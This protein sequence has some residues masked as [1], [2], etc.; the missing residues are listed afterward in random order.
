MDF[1]QPRMFSR[2]EAL[3]AGFTDDDLRRG[4]A[5]G[6]LHTVRRGYFIRSEVYS[7]LGPHARH[8]ALAEAIHAESSN[9]TVFSHVSAAVLHRM[10]TWDVPLDKVTFTIGRTYAGK[11][12]RHRIL[13]GSPIPPADLTEVDG[14]PVTTPARTVVDL[15]RTLAL[16]PAV[17]VGDAALRTGATTRHDIDRAL[18]ESRNRTGIARA[19][20]AAAM[21]S[22]RSDSVG[23]T[24]SRMLLDTLPLPPPLLGQWVYDEIGIPIGR[25]SFLYPDHGVLG[26]FEG[27]G[28][29]GAHPAPWSAQ[30][31]RRRD[32]FRSLG[33][34]VVQWNWSDLS[35]PRELTDRVARA[36]V[37]AAAQRAP[38][39]RFAPQRA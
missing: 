11:R 27:Q 39:G 15:A 24:R 34:V 32:D 31:E 1:D 33:W 35:N 20:Q 14:F 23:E 3:A 18:A 2:T 28:R 29:F 6:E 10:D 19:R 36:F 7:S 38:R 13:H 12:G 5:S 21:M 30:D 4:R 9:S 17:C 16:T 25:A 8:L 37:S 26:E 22:D